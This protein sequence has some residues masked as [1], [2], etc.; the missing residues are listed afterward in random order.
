MVMLISFHFIIVDGHFKC[1]ITEFL[2]NNGQC[3]N[4][5]LRCDGDF[6]CDDFSDES[7]CRMYYYY[8]YYS[9]IDFFKQS[10]NL[11]SYNIIL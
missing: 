11:Y 5:D 3:I 1:R 9:I 10:I 6:D 4:H 7:N 8:Y 2:C